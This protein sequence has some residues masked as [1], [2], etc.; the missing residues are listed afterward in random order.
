MAFEDRHGHAVR[1]RAAYRGLPEQAR[2]PVAGEQH[3]AAV[4]TAVRTIVHAAVG[5]VPLGVLVLR[6]RQLSPVH[7]RDGDIYALVTMSDS[8]SGLATPAKAKIP[9]L[10]GRHH[11]APRSLST[12]Y[13][14]HCAGD[15]DVRIAST[16]KAIQQQPTWACW[17][18]A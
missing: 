4:P 7:R 12:A 10:A 1:E 3:D 15:C 8:S 14:R 18:A 6:Q 9:G 5:A 13:F 11:R 17:R 2:G 16:R